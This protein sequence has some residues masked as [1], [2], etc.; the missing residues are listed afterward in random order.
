[1]K[2]NRDIY[3]MLPVQ[4]DCNRLEAGI[5]EAGRGCFAGPVVAAAVI[6][7]V[8]FQHPLL[9]DSKQVS[10]VHRNLLRTLIC[11][12]AVAWAVAFVEPEEIDKTNILKATFR[13]MHEAI[14]RLQVT[15]EK[16]L[17]D[18]N[19]FVAYPSIPHECIIKGDGTFAHI[20]AASILA[21]TFRDDYMIQIHDQYPQYGFHHHKGYGTAEHRMA[22]QKFGLTPIHRKS[23]NII[24]AQMKISFK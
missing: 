17:I 10:K 11:E 8:N 9:N 14:S 5:D 13:A 2:E 21:K 15:P 18:G 16:L 22:I 24:P 4:Q 12:E 6:L 3:I 19:R 1:M 7:P 23:F 20:A